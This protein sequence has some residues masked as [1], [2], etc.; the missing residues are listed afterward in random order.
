MG[1]TVVTGQARWMEE[2]TLS[3]RGCGRRWVLADAEHGKPREIRALWQRL[4]AA[5]R[6]C[7]VCDRAELELADQSARSSET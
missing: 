3:C 6:T 1:A 2:V 4:L 5:R 7:P